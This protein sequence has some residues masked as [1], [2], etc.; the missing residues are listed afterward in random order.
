MENAIAVV[1]GI[2]I[3]ALAMYLFRPSK[4]EADERVIKPKGVIPPSEA[5]ILNNEW[6]DKRKAAVDKAAGRPDN[7]SSWWSVE[8][9]QNYIVYAQNQTDGLGYKMDGLRVFLGVYPGNAP[10]GKADYTTMFLAPTGKKKLATNSLIHIENDHSS[11]GSDTIDGADVLNKG[12]N[13]HPP[14]SGYP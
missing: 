11:G 6:T 8:D 2:A 1:I 13:G 10:D 4:E 3:G 9:I 5:K 12:G 14:G 7:R